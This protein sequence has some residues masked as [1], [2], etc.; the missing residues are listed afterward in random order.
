MKYIFPIMAIIIVFMGASSAF[1]SNVEVNCP[2]EV[3]VGDTFDIVITI[4][5]NESLSGFEC[6]VNVPDNLK[7]INVLE[8]DDIR[9]KASNYYKNDFSDRNGIISFMLINEPMQS[10]FYLATIKV[11]VLKDSSN[12]TIHITPKAA[13]KDANE[14][15]MNNINLKLNVIDNI[16]DNSENNANE[17]IFSKIISFFKKLLG[18]GE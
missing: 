8:N 12:T 10:D 16:N 15:K 6:Q 3:N 9:K 4:K 18:L 2:S 7:I 1:A 5:N 13:D 14:I 17:G 11:K